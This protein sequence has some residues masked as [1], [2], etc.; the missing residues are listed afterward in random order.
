MACHSPA[1]HKPQRV[2]SPWL[3]GLFFFP[4]QWF[5]KWTKL[6]LILIFCT[7]PLITFLF[8]KPLPT[9]K[10][11]SLMSQKIIYLFTYLSYHKVSK[12]Q[13]LQ[14][15]LL[16]FALSTDFLN[17]GKII[18]WTQFTLLLHRND[19]LNIIKFLWLALTVIFQVPPRGPCIII[20]GVG[21]KKK[22]TWRSCGALI[23]HQSSGTVMFQQFSYMENFVQNSTNNQGNLL[24][25]ERNPTVSTLH[26]PDVCEMGPFTDRRGGM[27]FAPSLAQAGGAMYVAPCLPPPFQPILYGLNLLL[28]PVCTSALGD[29]IS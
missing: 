25:L 10:Y 20:T 3:H 28:K 29:F 17:A 9:H 2:L 13:T 23:Y 12:L 5:I 22:E 11:L 26:F 19:L 24:H 4:A 16:C 15:I 1:T 6:V 8:P 27:G 14:I 21:K 18:L 7:T